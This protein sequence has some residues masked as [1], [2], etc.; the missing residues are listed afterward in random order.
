MLQSDWL[1]YSLSIRQ[2]ISSNAR[3][4]SSVF[5]KKTR[6]N[7]NTNPSPNP[8]KIVILT[9]ILILILIILLIDVM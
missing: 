4:P 2:Y 9:L 8:Y 3:R 6:L 5:C 7:P 1:R